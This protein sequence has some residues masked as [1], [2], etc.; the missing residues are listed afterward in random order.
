MELRTGISSR[1]TRVGMYMQIGTALILKLYEGENENP[2]EAKHNF[3]Y[4]NPSAIDAGTVASKMV[5]DIMSVFKQDRSVT[6]IQKLADA[7]DILQRKTFG[8]LAG[9]MIRELDALMPK[10]ASGIKTAQNIV[11]NVSA[12]NIQGMRSSSAA[13]ITPT[14]SGSTATFITPASASS[15]RSVVTGGQGVIVAS[16]DNS[17]QDNSTTVNNFSGSLSN[18]NDPYR[19]NGSS[20]GMLATA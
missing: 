20:T 15:S 3:N 18:S 6:E 10:K 9:G 17:T 11:S 4:G 8:T 5:N 2:H 14:S 12:E 7:A 19:M 13:S 1:I 16:S